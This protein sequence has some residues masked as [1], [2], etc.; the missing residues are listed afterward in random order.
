MHEIKS[1]YTLDEIYLCKLC[2]SSASCINLYCIN[3]YHAIYITNTQ[4]ARMNK[5]NYQEVLTNS[6]KLVMRI[7]CFMQS[8]I[9]VHVKSVTHE[10][11]LTR[12]LYL[13]KLCE[14]GAGRINLY[15][16]NFYRTIWYF[17][18]IIRIIRKV[19]YCIAVYLTAHILKGVVKPHQNKTEVRRTMPFSPSGYNPNFLP[20]N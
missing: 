2:E 8:I 7:N 3:F 5:F 14:S 19:L 10:T 6:H 13:C 11:D 17:T 4:N 9:Y 1:I 16:I 12:D 15:C 20:T 18:H